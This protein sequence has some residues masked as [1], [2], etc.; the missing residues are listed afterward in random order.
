[1]VEL[2]VALPLIILLFSGLVELGF[3]LNYYLSLL[4]ATR[5]AARVY[6]TQDPFNDDLSDNM[7]FYQSTASMVY[8][9][10]A[11]YNAQDT[12]RKIILDPN[13]DDI[14]VSVFNVTNSGVTNPSNVCNQAQPNPEKIITRRPTAGE[15]RY[16]ENHSSGVNTQD[17]CDHLIRGS[18]PTAILL[19]E[20]Y[21]GYHQTIALP[22][23]APFMSNPV[24][25]HAQTMMPMPPTTLSHKAPMD[26]AFL[27]P[28]W[29]N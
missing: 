12:T 8:T 26:I 15:F 10:L 16:Y 22:W 4:D 2:A 6:S 19:V 20:V 27:L 29:E 9:E 7:L 17:I 3:I 25:L 28:P 5:E 13:T 24:V 1:M 11:P 18:S 21:Y 23:L 14:I